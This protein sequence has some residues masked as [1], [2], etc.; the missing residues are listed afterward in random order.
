M[1]TAPEPREKTRESIT[2]V[3]GAGTKVVNLTGYLDIISWDVPASETFKFSIKG[4][5]GLEYYLSP[6]VLTGDT[7]VILSP[8]VP[9]TGKM[10]ITIIGGSADGVYYFTP[11]GNLK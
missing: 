9:M 11:I 5:S 2:V 10:T 7:T 8:S 3:S 1:I 6:T 4:A